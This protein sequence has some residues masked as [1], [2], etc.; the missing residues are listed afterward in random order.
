[1]YCIS[2]ENFFFSNK[3]KH[4]FQLWSTKLQIQYEEVWTVS[5]ING[6]LPDLR[7]C[8]W[9]PDESLDEFDLIY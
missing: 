4:S 7:E 1:M 2:F 3:S 5:L 6:G 8:E 9:T